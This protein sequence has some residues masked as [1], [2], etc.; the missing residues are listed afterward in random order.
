MSPLVRTPDV[1]ELR[2]FCIAADLG[3]LGRAA[4]RLHVS[5]PAL[6]KRVQSLE[7]LAGVRLLDRSSRG[8]TLTPAGRR[9]YEHARRLLEQAEAVEAVI[10]GL[11]RDRGPLLLAASH[12]AAEGFVGE[13]LARRTETGAPIELVTANSQLV[14]QLVA[15]GRAEL[16]VA[17]ARP[18]GTPNP[19]AREVFLADDEI[20][21]AVPDTHRWRRRSSVSLEEFVREPV[22]VR[23]PSSNARRTVDAELRRRDLSPPP[24]L[25][26]AP[27]P[28]AA[29]RES[30]A[31]GAAVLLSERVL[32]GEPFARLEIRGLRFPRR[33]VAVLP[34]VG[35]PS[36]EVAALLEQLRAEALA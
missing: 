17:A 36:S 25:A 28:A 1:V 4:V 11:Q 19:G 26:Q 10:E 32:R 18:G 24:L 12:S 8:V 22:V 14:R 35:E 20:V 2:S 21:Y 7:A 15:D 6:S 13:L 27:T 30:R 31:R 34:A 3:S 16:G 23:D 33:W 29:K 9:L 5:Q